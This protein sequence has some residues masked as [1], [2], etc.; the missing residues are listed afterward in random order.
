MRGSSSSKTSR[1]R[2][3]I[4]LVQHDGL[5][6]LVQAGAVAAELTVDGSEALH[7][8]AVRRIDH[9]QEQARALQVREELVAEPDALARTLDQ[10]RHV[11]HGQLAPVGSVH[12]AEHGREGCEGV[13]GDLRL[14]VRDAP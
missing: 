4:D 7:G 10:P 1:L 14:R 11:G 3:E 6:T 9:V 8:I 2:Q 13:V 12:R 5:R